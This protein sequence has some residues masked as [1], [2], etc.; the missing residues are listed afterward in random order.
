MNNE[1]KKAI[2]TCQMHSEVKQDAPGRCPKC[3]MNLVV[4]DADTA[5]NEHSH[6]SH[7]GC[8]G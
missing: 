7:G 3:G 6:K 4:A 8:C 5:E 1:P 2:Y